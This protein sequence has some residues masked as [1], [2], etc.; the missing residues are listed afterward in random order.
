MSMNAGMYDF[1]GSADSFAAGVL[2]GVERVFGNLSEFD[3]GR[4]LFALFVFVL[5]FL[6][7]RL[8]RHVFFTIVGKLFTL[9]MQSFRDNLGRSLRGPVELMFVAVGTFLAFEV[10]KVTEDST[11]SQ[12]SSHVVQT[13]LIAAAY[14]TIIA[15]ID[16]LT[17]Q[18]APRSA[19]L[20][21]TVIDWIR[22]SLKCVVLFFAIVALLQQWGVRIG[23]L[24]AGMGI[25]GAAVALGAQELFKNLISGVLI[26][27]ERRFQYG[28]WVKVQNV[29]EGTVESIGFRSTRIRQFDD[30][31]VEVPNSDL[32][33]NAVINYTQMRRRRIYWIIGVPY[34]TT[35][36]QLRDIRQ[37][38]EDYIHTEED[39]VSYK[40][41]STF[42]RIDSFGASSINIMVYCF[43]KTT[44]WG[45]WLAVKERLA[46]KLMDIVTGAGSSFAF[47]STSLYVESL[48]ADRPEVFLPPEAGKP[49]VKPM[50]EA[51]GGPAS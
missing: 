10:L 19:R 24:L 12:F 50:A 9:N 37:K 11:A 44:H 20:T 1:L 41:A 18:V 8:F 33:D 16:P 7:R 46:Y 15:L 25:A 29:V 17:E 28:D 47:P 26:L 22:K 40:M 49:Q 14:W 31:A 5:F 39:F 48:P 36:E 34:S 51:G 23:P 32:A 13:L 27:L 21:E 35:V 3:Y 43:T 42:V 30:A 45:E 2:S 6:L 4:I 38:I